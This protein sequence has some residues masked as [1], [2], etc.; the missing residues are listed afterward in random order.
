MGTDK[1]LRRSRTAEP[2]GGVSPADILEQLERILGHPE[3]HATEKMKAFLRFVV[4]ETLE[5]RK[6][7]IKGYTIATKVFGRGD[8]FDAG[9]DPIVSIQAGRLRRALERY[10]LV[11]GGRDPVH[12]D[13]PKGRYIPRFKAQLTAAPADDLRSTIPHDQPRLLT[14]PTLA[15]V[16]LE[17]LSPDPEQQFLTLGLTNELVTE[18]NRFQDIVVMPC[19]SPADTLQTQSPTAE[20]PRVPAARFILR[21]TVRTDP[22]TFRVS[23]QLTDAADGHQLWAEAYTHPL[24][25]GRFIATQEDIA[26]SVVAAIASEYGI[27]ARRLAAESRRKPPAEL[28]TYEAML[29]YY[30]HQITPSPESAQACLAALR[31]SAERE[32]DYGPVWSALAT[33]HCQMY[34][35]DAPGSEN[36]LET[37][38]EY[39][40]KG[41]FL[42]PGS[43]LG[44]LILAYAGHLADDPDVFAQESETA[45]ALNPNSPYTVG[46]IGYFHVM[47]GSFVRG[48][49]LLERAMAVNPCHPNWFHA[50]RVIHLISRR[51]YEEALAELEKHDPFFA[52]WL[53]VVR[54][55]ILGNL[56]R[57]DEARTHLHQVR[58]QKPDF[59]SRARELF[60]RS[61]KV[62]SIIDDLIDGL[63]AAGLQF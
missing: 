43:Q 60:R 39:A 37:A 63:R 41:V 34:S 8:D 52:F 14:G 17:D 26:R 11:A 53:P 40:R 23:M 51:S 54:A 4:E 18:L 29:R 46:A 30:T 27:I 28:D 22:A 49:P 19:D 25:A 57:L 12:V 59:A 56:G 44:R 5:G 24:E 36:A 3:F 6:H 15:V 33:L 47:R 9:Q 32:P 20:Q 48:L 7:R 35:F 10:Y 21:G 31:R 2:L 50:G 38:Q 1:P 55:S 42:E 61:L 45:L 13:I 62:D 16:P 58:E